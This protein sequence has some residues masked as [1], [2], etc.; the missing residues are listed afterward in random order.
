MKVSSESELQ[1]IDASRQTQLEL[2]L[3]IDAS[4]WLMSGY[5]GED[6]TAAS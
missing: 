3:L 6:R 1:V 2:C 4:N 5:Q